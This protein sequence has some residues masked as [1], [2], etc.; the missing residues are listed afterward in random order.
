[1]G[2]CHSRPAPGAETPA[3]PSPH[4][5]EPAQPTQGAIGSCDT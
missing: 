2:I 3:R 5:G 1:M 4:K